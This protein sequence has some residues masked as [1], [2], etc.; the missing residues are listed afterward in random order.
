[1]FYFFF[2]IIHDFVSD[3]VGR[4]CENFGNK[5]N[6]FYTK[7]AE[8]LFDNIFNGKIYLSFNEYFLFLKCICFV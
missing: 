6:N 7:G 1:M 2:Q 4:I 8:H 5:K 3:G